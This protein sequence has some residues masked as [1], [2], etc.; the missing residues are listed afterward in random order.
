MDADFERGTVIRRT[1][2]GRSA[3]A[4]PAVYSSA[5]MGVREI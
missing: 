4:V 5:P 1:G 3:E 2:P